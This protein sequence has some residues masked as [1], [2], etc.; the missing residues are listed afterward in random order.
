MIV[1]RIKGM[2]RRGDQYIN[3]IIDIAK[4]DSHYLV[5]K[6]MCNNE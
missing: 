2:E 4:S 3:Y 1:R 5:R 6:M